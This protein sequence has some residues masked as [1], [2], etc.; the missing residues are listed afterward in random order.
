MKAKK[1]LTLDT[2]STGLGRKALAFDVAYTIATRRDV[3]LSRQFLIREIL[4]DPRVML[5]AMN[6]G[7]WRD[8][9]GA[10]LF[11]NYIPAIDSQE[12]RLASWQDFTRTLRADMAAHGV[13]VFAAYNLPFDMRAIAQTQEHI[14]G[15]SKVLEYRPDLLCLWNFSAS[16]VC[17]RPTYHKAAQ[18]F[19]WISDAGNVRTN[20]E[21]VY[22]YLTGDF[23]FIETH[24]ALDD[25]LI[26]TEILQR[27]L[28]NKKPIPYNELDHGAWRKAQRIS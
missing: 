27:L 12:Y 23:D 17:Q 15:K 20:A 18:Q 8:M 9:M 19:G 13:D 25:A 11:A 4:T 14:L 26:E 7:E 28:A 2:E 5:G 21:K 6:N 10:K 24:T 1:F 3:I 22:A 16:T